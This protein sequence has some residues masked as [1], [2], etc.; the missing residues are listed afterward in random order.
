MTSAI[1]SASPVEGSGARLLRSLGLTRTIGYRECS[2]NVNRRKRL[3]PSLACSTGPA[4]RLA[5]CG[6]RL[7]LAGRAGDD[8]PSHLR[9][10]PEN[11]VER[12][13]TPP[14]PVR[15]RERRRS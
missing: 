5:T 2:A 6:A 15:R 3:L 9:K 8:P 11:G 7:V 4:R 12:A 13:G 14:W 10:R 1:A